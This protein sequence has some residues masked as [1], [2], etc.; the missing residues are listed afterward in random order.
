MPFHEAP[1]VFVTTT[2]YLAFYFGLTVRRRARKCFGLQPNIPCSPKMNW[3]KK[4]LCEALDISDRIDPCVSKTSRAVPARHT[5]QDMG[6]RLVS[7]QVAWQLLLRPLRTMRILSFAK[8]SCLY[9][10]TAHCRSSV[11]IPSHDTESRGTRELRLFGNIL[12]CLVL[13]CVPK[14][15]SVP[16]RKNHIGTISEWLHKR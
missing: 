10:T 5:L 7:I 1:H 14:T 6:Y 3:N 13:Y 8:H 16:L 2:P 11:R 15:G 4:S 9:K 12:L